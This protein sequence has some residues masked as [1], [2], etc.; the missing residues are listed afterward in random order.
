[1]FQKLAHFVKTSVPVCNKMGHNH[2]NE[3]FFNGFASN[4]EKE[5]FG[6]VENINNL[7]V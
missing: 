2:E 7:K 4:H 5:N 1:M 3:N 6:A